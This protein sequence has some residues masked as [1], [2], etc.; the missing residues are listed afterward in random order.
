LVVGIVLGVLG[1]RRRLRTERRLRNEQSRIAARDQALRELI[2]ATKPVRKTLMRMS[3]TVS[4]EGEILSDWPPLT[5]WWPDVQEQLAEIADRWEDDWRPSLG[6]DPDLVDAMINVR[7][8]AVV[9]TLGIGDDGALSTERREDFDQGTRDVA[10]GAGKLINLGSQ[11][12][13]GTDPRPE[14]GTFR[15]WWANVNSKHRARQRR[16]TFPPRAH[17]RGARVIDDEPEPP[18]EAAVEP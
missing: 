17:V 12:F 4:Q 3:P 16:K 9:A 7:I 11:I 8:G 2:A 6:D 14:K 5:R 15:H 10:S 18:D 1:E 13:A